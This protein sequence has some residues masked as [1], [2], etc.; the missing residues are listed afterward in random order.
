MRYLSLAALLLAPSLIVALPWGVAAAPGPPVG[1]ELQVPVAGQ[2]GLDRLRRRADR[3][4]R[5]LVPRA[6][7]PSNPGD[8]A[9]RLHLR[10][11]IDRL[12]QRLR[13]LEAR[14]RQGFGGRAIGGEADALEHR[15]D[16]LRRR[17]EALE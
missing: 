17:R 5:G 12:Q 4:E 11:H 10:H 13:G 15:Y 2:G 7:G 8:S 3:L 16:L 1:V 6:P 9:A 14:R